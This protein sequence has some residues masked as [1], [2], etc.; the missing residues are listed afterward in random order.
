MPSTHKIQKPGNQP[1]DRTKD[2]IQYSQ[3]D[4][5]LKSR[6]IHLLWGNCKKHSVIKKTLDQENETSHFPFLLHCRVHY[7]I[8]CFYSS[9][10]TSTP[11][12]PIGSI[13]APVLPYCGK[14]YIKTDENLTAY[15]ENCWKYSCVEKPSLL[16]RLVTDGPTYIRESCM[17]GG[18]QHSQTSEILM[19][20]QDT[21]STY[22]DFKTTVINMSDQMLYDEVYSLLQ[23]GLNFAV[24]PHTTTYWRH[25]SWCWKGNS[26]AT[27]G[28]GKRSQ[29][30]DMI[31]IK[32]SSRP[33]DNLPK[34]K[35]KALQALKKNTTLT[36]LPVDKAMP[37]WFSTLLTTSR[38]SSPF[39]RV[40]PID[41]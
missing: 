4:E 9:I 3:H 33:T 27:S 8:P 23:K 13:N 15:L 20:P 12:L 34:A 35:R 6:I 21:P 1:K 17:S 22:K 37:V 29:A 16:V 5:S 30:R 40:Y 38:R 24:T 2:R 36:I 10:T 31:I 11:A 39:L 41:G 19:A 14:G 28:N 32:S 7:T 18:R 26:V 25:L